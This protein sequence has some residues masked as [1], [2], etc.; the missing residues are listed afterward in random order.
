MQFYRFSIV[1][2]CTRKTVTNAQYCKNLT[3]YCYIQFYSFLHEK[4]ITPYNFII[5]DAYMVASG[6]PKRNGEKHVMEIAK[7]AID[8][9]SEKMQVPHREHETIELRIGINTGNA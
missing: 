7:L 2:A 8:L 9:I 1:K 5:G 4:N 6:L 3:L